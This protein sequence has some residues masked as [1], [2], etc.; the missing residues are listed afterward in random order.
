MENNPIIEKFLEYQEKI[1]DASRKLYDIK[2]ERIA[3]AQE[4]RTEIKSLFPKKGK[5]YEIIEMP[6]DWR[7]EDYEDDLYYFKPTIT[8]FAPGAV[9][10][11]LFSPYPMVTGD[12]LDCNLKKIDISS[13]EIPINCLREVVEE[14]SPDRMSDNITKVYVMIDKNTG[15]YK[16]GRSKNPEKREK[17]LQSEKPTIEMIF[18]E[19][20][21]IRDEKKLHYIFSDKRIRGEWFDL[22]GTDLN[23]IREYFKSRTL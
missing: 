5:V 17:T 22:N 7:Y 6:S 9:F 15:Y 3:W 8:R 11:F 1:D 2:D 4:N 20:A 16:I 18:N 23:K 19:D 12:L 14:R 21:R 10:A 13:F